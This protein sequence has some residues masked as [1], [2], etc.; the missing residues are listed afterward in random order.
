M[1]E[2][3]ERQAGS[4]TAGE[5]AFLIVGKVRRPHGVRGDVLVEICTDFPERLAP[6]TLVYLGKDRLPLTIEN[7]RPHKDGLLILFAGLTTPEQAGLYRNQNLYVPAED[8]PALPEGEYY[9][10]QLIGLRVLDES[11]QALGV[12]HEIL[13]TGANDVYVLAAEAGKEILLPAI[14]E[15]ILDVDLDAGVMKV[16]LLPGLLDT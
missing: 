2:D 10:H 7:Q 8:R 15:T 5:P 12:L 6:G 11:G 3:V 1:P 16:H 4:P 14:A 9:H 13:E